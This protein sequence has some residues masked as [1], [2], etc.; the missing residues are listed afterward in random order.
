MTKLTNAQVVYLEVLNFNKIDCISK[1]WYNNVRQNE[2]DEGDLN[3]EK[4]KN[5]QGI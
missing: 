1:L 4:S 5:K 2:D 3:E